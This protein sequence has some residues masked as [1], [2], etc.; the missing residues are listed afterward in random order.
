MVEE[1]LDELSVELSKACDLAGFI[2]SKLHDISIPNTLRNRVAAACYA[3]ALDHFDAILVLLRSNPKLYSSAFSLMRLVFETF[4]RGMWL[5]HCAE[6]EQVERFSNNEFEL[7]KIKQLI[8]EVEEKC[9]FDGKELSKS[10]SEYWAVLCDYTH[11]GVRQIQRWH[12]VEGVEP[13]YQKEEI[14]DVIRFTT[15]YAVL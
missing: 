14:I 4:I 5:L 7:P 13:N 9:N 2:S 3:I 15:R 1:S 6:D 8:N 10:H 11:T 12:S